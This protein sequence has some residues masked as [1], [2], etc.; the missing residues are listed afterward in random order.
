MTSP[1]PNLKQLKNII[2]NTNSLWQILSS[3]SKLTNSLWQILNSPVPVA[4]ELIVEISLV[5]FFI[6]KQGFALN[7]INYSIFNGCWRKL[8]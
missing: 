3:H 7:P 8:N 1:G 6:S 2:Q 5:S 4:H